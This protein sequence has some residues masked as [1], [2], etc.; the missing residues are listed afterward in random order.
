MADLSSPEL[1]ALAGAERPL[2]GLVRAIQR[3]KATIEEETAALAEGGPSGHGEFRHRK[4]LCLLDL[5]RRSPAFV[6]P[7]RD[8]ELMAALRD[9]K[10]AIIKNQK[11][12]RCHINAAR[13][14]SAIIMKA[15]AD[16]DSDR[17][18]TVYSL[19]QAPR[20]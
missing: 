2:D 16:E 9:L 12:L 7:P 1:H 8:P 4:D 3:T 11:A 15:I 13:Q 17:T 19:R 20:V 18:Y 6:D 10:D 5:S 14:V